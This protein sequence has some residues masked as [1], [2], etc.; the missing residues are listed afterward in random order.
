MSWGRSYFA[1][2][3][4]AGGAW[5][6]AVF[7]SP[8]V[9]T[10]T[11]GGVDPVVVAALDIPLF[12][13]ASA[14]AALGVRPAAVLATGWTLIVTGGLGVYATVTTEAGWGVLIMVAASGGSVIA[15]CFMLC[16][17]MPTEWIVAR[18]PFAFRPATT[19]SAT[20]S[21]VASTLVQLVIFWG[22]F[23]AVLPLMLSRLEQRWGLALSLPA[24]VATAGSV[25]FLLASA[26]GLWSAVA[27][28]MRGGGTPLPSAMPNQLVV[29]GPY[30]FVRNPMAIA[31]I[32]QGAAVG[33]MLSSWLVV[34]YAL[35]GSLVWNS[36]VRPLEEADLEARFGDEFRRY[37]RAVRCWRPRLMPVT[38]R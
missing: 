24:D 5:W 12:V 30:R 25:V 19:R 8:V 38:A 36:V 2:Q 33:L 16:G 31:G 7:V 15:M 37:K 10:S 26:L 13:C 3:A 34:A 29:A 14:L 21:H 32:V 11:L 9:R 35:A 20:G 4:V 6:V 27:M 28:S 1:A 18:G 17:R 22:F 23:L